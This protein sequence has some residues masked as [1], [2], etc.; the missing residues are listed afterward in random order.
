MSY[1][2]VERLFKILSYYFDNKAYYFIINHQAVA[3][4]HNSDK[5]FMNFV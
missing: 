2:Y 5:K 3:N 1:Q 4:Y